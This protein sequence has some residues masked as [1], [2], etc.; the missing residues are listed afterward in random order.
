MQAARGLR[1]GAAALVGVGYVAVCQW[2]MTSAPASPWN[3]VGVL[4]PMLLMIAAGCRGR[5]RR[6]LGAVAL[7][8]LAALVLQAWRGARVEPEPL[9]LAQHAGVNLCLAAGF[10]MTLRPGRTALITALARRVHRRLT[11][12]MAVYTR[13]CTL[14]WVVYFVA[15]AALSVGLFAFAPFERWAW[16]ANVLSPLTIALMFVGEYGLRYRLHPEFERVTF[17]AAIRAYR[18]WGAER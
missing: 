10:A 6:G 17:A 12:A 7:V 14:A 4:G 1:T 5:G 13:H 18:E 9:Y 2:L 8:G 3:A 15:V 16:F 11:P